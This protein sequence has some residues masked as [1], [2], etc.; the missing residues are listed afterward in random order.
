VRL[1]W[2]RC[3]AEGPGGIR[4]PGCSKLYVPLGKTGAS[5]APY[6]FVFRLTQKPSGSLAWSMIAF[7]VR[8]PADRHT[9]SVYE[10]AHKRLHRH[11][12][13]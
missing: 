13:G 6:G 9:R 7:G 3:E 4:L 8:H 10:R 2:Q 12:P 11:F 5:D 1:D